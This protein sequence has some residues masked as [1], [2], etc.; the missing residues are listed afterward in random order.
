M[1]TGTDVALTV[2]AKELSCPM[3]IVKLA[4]GITEIEIGQVIEVQATDEAFIPDAEAW[5]RKTG[6]ELLNKEEGQDLYRAYIKR[7]K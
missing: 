4:T 3:P 1:T 6:H 7:T 2:D 5:C